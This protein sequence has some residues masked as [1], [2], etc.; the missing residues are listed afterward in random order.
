MNIHI[1][2]SC[3]IIDRKFQYGTQ[4]VI[5]R[6]QKQESLAA[7][8]T[9]IYHE[10]K[11]DYPK[12]FKMDLLCK[13]GF[14]ASEALTSEHF[15]KTT[16][17]NDAGIILFNSVSSLEADEKYRQTI[18]EEDCF[19]SPA[20][21]VYTLP[22]IV[23]GELAIRNKM[24]GESMFYVLPKYDPDQMMTI[25]TDTFNDTPLHTALCGWID[26]AGEEAVVHLFLVERTCS[27]G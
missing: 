23:T 3:H 27:S 25:I 5:D 21:F 12:F 4:T 6:S 24:L 7:F 22:N 10:M 17:K 2:N 20:L 14:L 19:P 13:A 26:V 15:D 9:A 1:I 16:P 8:F 18:N 11:I